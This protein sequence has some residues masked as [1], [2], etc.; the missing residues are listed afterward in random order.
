MWSPRQ[1]NY[2]E[3]W[4]SSKVSRYNQVIKK[5]AYLEQAFEDFLSFRQDFVLH[6]H[7]FVELHSIKDDL[8]WLIV[9]S[10]TSLCFPMPFIFRYSFNMYWQCFWFLVC[11][12]TIGRSWQHVSWSLLTFWLSLLEWECIV[13]I[14]ACIFFIFQ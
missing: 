12:Y 1:I 4:A 9:N 3:K 2:W 7:Y 13:N 5:V 10:V 14:Q 11:T 6:K 8:L